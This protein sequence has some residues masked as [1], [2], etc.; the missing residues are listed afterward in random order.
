MT[1]LKSAPIPVSAF[2]CPYCR[3]L[4]G[5]NFLCRI[6]MIMC[7]M[8]PIENVEFVDAADDGI[9]YYE[10]IDSF[11]LFNRPAEKRE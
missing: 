5:S 9:I 4:F 8:K 6:H 3:A 7:A 2:E 11:E 1:E 10:E